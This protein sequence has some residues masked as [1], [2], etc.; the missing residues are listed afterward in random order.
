MNISKGVTGFILCLWTWIIISNR[1]K[2]NPIP[3]WATILHALAF[4]AF[5]SVW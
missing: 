1:S 4:A 3:Q 5:V 2:G